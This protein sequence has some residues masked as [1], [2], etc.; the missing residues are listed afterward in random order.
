[1]TEG[2]KKERH[3]KLIYSKIYFKKKIFFKKGLLI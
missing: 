3:K 2:L 1:M